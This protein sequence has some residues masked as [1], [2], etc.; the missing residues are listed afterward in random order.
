MIIVMIAVLII[1][2]APVRAAGLIR[3][4]EI[5]RALAEIAAPILNAAGIGKNRIK[6][7]VINSS[8]LNA[9]VAD[10]SHIYI[11]SGLILKLKT[12]EQL[13]AV[14]A[15]EAAHISNGHINRR[16]SNARSA[17][18]AAGIGA[19]LAAAAAV[20]GNGEAAA[21]IALGTQ[22]SAKRVF[23]GHTRAEEN[24]ADQSAA[25]Y[26]V[27]AKVN[28]QAMVEVLNIFRG[29]EALNINRRDP[30]ASTHPLH[31]DRIRAA[32]GYAAAYGGTSA[33]P[34]VNTTYWYARVRAK[35]G[36]FLQNPSY[37]LRRVKKSDKS[38]IA[39]LTRAIAYH[40]KP[41]IKQAKANINALLSLRPNDPY[42]TELKGQILLESREFAAAAPVYQRAVKLAPNE[43]LFLADYGRALLA[44]KQYKS[45]LSVLKKAYGRDGA[46]PR[47]LRNLA[48][49]YA[50]AGNNGMASSATAERYAVLGR[51]SDAGIH[52]N[53]AMGLLPRGSSAWLRAQ[54]ISIAAERAGAKKK[55]KR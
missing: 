52:A 44:A 53:R 24:S 42:Y 3:D 23:F 4:A 48:Q 29:Q 47:L 54:D 11:H 20:S 14:I 28:P 38:E 9:F 5:E 50:H 27:R 32:K 34:S 36:G 13:Q 39:L 7:R 55:R 1:S 46:N 30:Y 2:S 16:L 21:G 45:A 51:L 26:M 33:K 10:H 12:V 35:L 8:S 40:K 41:D 43:P 17:K 49:A 22:S 31:S 18:T 19:L 6:I 25:R 15:H 37:T